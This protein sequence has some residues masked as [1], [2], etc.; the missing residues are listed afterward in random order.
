MQDEPQKWGHWSRENMGADFCELRSSQ[1]RGQW[2][3]WFFFKP[4]P[5]KKNFPPPCTPS[6]PRKVTPRELVLLIWLG[7]KAPQR[8]QSH[9]SQEATST[10]ILSCLSAAITAEILIFWAYSLHLILPHLPTAN[11]LFSAQLLWWL[12]T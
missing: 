6:L 10:F 7:R 8:L 12:T 1:R 3:Q 2:H 9:Q 5:S 11:F 4:A